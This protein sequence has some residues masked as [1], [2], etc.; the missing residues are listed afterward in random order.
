[1]SALFESLGSVRSNVESR[2]IEDLKS[3][4][5]AFVPGSTVASWLEVNIQQWEDFSGYW[6][7]LTTDCYMGDGGT[8]RLRRYEEFELQRP[9]P[10]CQLPH[11]PYEQPVYINALNGGIRREF[12]PLEP[13]FAQHEV[14]E[15]LLGS[16]ADAL[17]TVER[18]HQRWNIRLHPYRIRADLGTAGQP[19]PEGLHRD[20]VDYIVTMMI[21]RHHINGGETSMTDAHQR[22]LWQKTLSAPMDMVIAD[23][24]RVMHSVTAVTP[25]SSGHQAYRD[26]LVVA[27]TKI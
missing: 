6:D 2:L 17:D 13:G 24:H 21:R 4:D 15:R 22:P 12:D 3:T 1:M 11:G 26:V 5:F 18:D 20:G 27:Y 8:Y 25:T 23:D 7:R 14:L 9:A 10:M 19:T 16:L